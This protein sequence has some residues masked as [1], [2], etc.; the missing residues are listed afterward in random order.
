MTKRL[1]SKLP[2]GE[3]SALLKDVLTGD[4]TSTLATGFMSE[5]ARFDEESLPDQ[6]ISV[7]QEVEEES[8]SQPL[9]DEPKR[10]YNGDHHDDANVRGVT[11]KGETHPPVDCDHYDDTQGHGISQDQME[12][13]NGKELL[14]VLS[15]DFDGVTNPARK[16]LAVIESD[17]KPI[18]LNPLST[19]EKD[20]AIQMKSMEGKEYVEKNDSK[21]RRRN[22]IRMRL[23]S[24][25][26]DTE[27]DSL[28]IL[29]SNKRKLEADIES[30]KMNKTTLD[31]S[32][33]V[34]N[35]AISKK[36]SLETPS[37]GEKS[38]TPY[39]LPRLQEESQSNAKPYCQD[40]FG[41]LK[42]HD[43]ST[44]AKK[45]RKANKVEPLHEKAIKYKVGEVYTFH[46][47]AMDRK[48]AVHKD[49]TKWRNDGVKRGRRDNVVHSRYA[50]LSKQNGGIRKMIGHDEDTNTII[51]HYYRI[52]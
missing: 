23:V 17:I 11:L 7:K 28:S 29:P 27:S 43:T 25:S 49:G 20:L 19:Q 35:N 4:Q 9:K 31:S 40:V 39:G 48:F 50:P 26:S 8:I 32:L 18:I 46:G 44:I 34:D 14:R 45:A 10:P 41:A 52:N 24:E 22:R 42:F 33:N 38:R 12:E 21:K 30:S 15:N 2:G 1:L 6:E 3:V 36:T 16:N 47:T 37:G 51:I 13:T 5:V